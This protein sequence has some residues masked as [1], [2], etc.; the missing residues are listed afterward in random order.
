MS[1]IKSIWEHFKNPMLWIV[2]IGFIVAINSDMRDLQ[3]LTNKV[4]VIES[5]QNKK[6]TIQNEHGDHLKDLEIRMLEKEIEFL[7]KSHENELRILKL[8]VQVEHLEKKL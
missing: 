1:E 5:R 3:H 7:K 6:I 8:E 2:L 4:D